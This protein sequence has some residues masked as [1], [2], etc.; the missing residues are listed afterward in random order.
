MESRAKEETLETLD[1]LR[2]EILDFVRNLVRIPS[3]VGSEGRAQE[4]IKGKFDQMQLDTR[5]IQPDKATL[6]KHPGYCEVPWGYEDRP[7]VIGIWRGRTPKR[8]LIL[9]G[10]IDVVTPEP[11]HLWNHDPWGAEI[12]GGKLYGRG[13]WDMKAGIAAM[14]YAVQSLQKAGIELDGDVILESVIEEEAGGSGGTLAVLLD[15]IRADAAII[16]EPSSLNLWLASNGVNYFRVRVEGKTAHPMRAKSGVDAIEKAFWV[17]DALKQLSRR[18]RA[19]VRY[20]LFEGESDYAC[21]L[22]VGVLRAGDWPSAVPGW[23]EMDC[24]LSFTPD[25]RMEEIKELVERTIFQK[26]QEDL[27]LRD[28]PPQVKWFGWSA[29]PSKQ[30]SDH[31]LVQIVRRIATEECGIEPEFRGF[32]GGLD[33]RLFLQY[34]GIPAFCFGPRGNGIHG[35][36]EFVIIEDIFKVTKVLACML[37]EWLTD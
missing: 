26:S 4:F 29:H 25:E 8:S 35:I 28:H 23:A 32:A 5:L 16:P 30:S 31:P 10:H 18:R 19:E 36:D 3:I 24:R 33:T 22:N 9:N 1:R 15:G 13:A 6:Q 34:G 17:W 21:D 11:I 27:W 2:D 14:I 37:L 20:P 7:N 12:E